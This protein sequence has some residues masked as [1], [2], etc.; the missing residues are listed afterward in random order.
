MHP[1]EGWQARLAAGRSEGQTLGAAAHAGTSAC[2]GQA[3]WL[4]P[5]CSPA[6][7]SNREGDVTETR[8]RSPLVRA[9]SLI[10]NIVHTA[11]KRCPQGPAQ[12]HRA[13]KESA[14]GAERQ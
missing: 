3:P 6:D 12:D 5:H 1:T 4:S 11:K 14:S 10:Y 8:K 2:S 9:V 13:G 7:V